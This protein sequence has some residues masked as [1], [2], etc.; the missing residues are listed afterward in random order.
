MEMKWLLK[1]LTKQENEHNHVQSA[2]NLLFLEGDCR[3]FLTYFSS[4]SA[5]SCSLRKQENWKLTWGDIF[6]WQKALELFVAQYQP[7]WIKL[8]VDSD[9]QILWHPLHLSQ[10]QPITT[11]WHQQPLYS[12]AQGLGQWF[13]VLLLPTAADNCSCTPAFSDVST[14][15]KSH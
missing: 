12:I 10:Q 1:E 11:S 9:I 15:I 14:L 2:V 8:S 4:D 5:L 3:V 7:N 13:G 6:A